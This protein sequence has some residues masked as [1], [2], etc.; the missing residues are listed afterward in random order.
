M[1]RLYSRKK[2]KSGSKKPLEKKK[3]PWVRYKKEEIESLVVKLGKQ[4]IKPSK[5]GLILRDTYGIPDVK[6]LTDKR[7]T[8]ILKEN[9]VVYEL[10]EDLLNLIKR[11]IQ[12][13]K[14]FEKNKQDKTAKRGLQL[15]ESKINRLIKY[16]KKS[17]KL[18]RSWKY[19]K[20]KAK[21]LVGV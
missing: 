7:I 12:I 20:S 9:K 1:A 8:K 19:D 16:Y 3:L 14:H 2:G 11:Q 5:I 4:E 15:T 18:S 6:F 13:I 17:G 10:P 21:L